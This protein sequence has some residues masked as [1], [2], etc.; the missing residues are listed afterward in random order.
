MREGLQVLENKG[1]VVFEPSIN[2]PKF[3]ATRAGLEAIEQN[4]VERVISD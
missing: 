2:F 4:A 3:R 1:L